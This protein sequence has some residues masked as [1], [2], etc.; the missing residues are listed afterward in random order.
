MATRRKRLVKVILLG[1]SGVGKSSLVDQYVHNKFTDKYKATIGVDFTTKEV[2]VGDD[3]MTLQI[4]DTAGQERFKSL[5]VSFYRGTNACVLVFDVTSHRT[6]QSLETWRE[7][8]LVHGSLATENNEFSPFFVLGNKTDLKDR[9]V[10]R[11][12]AEEWCRSK[13]EVLPYFETS[14]K[15]NASVAKVFETIARNARKAMVT[16]EPEE[17]PLS[18]VKPVTNDIASWEGD[19]T[20]SQ[21][22]C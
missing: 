8:F 4:W 12:T 13:K 3:V 14:A 9:E 6:F 21:C 5:G 15:D 17:T 2:V 11:E 7:D 1:D 20:K 16:A 19:E 22:N 18:V 10:C